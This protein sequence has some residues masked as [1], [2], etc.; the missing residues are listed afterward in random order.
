[1]GD[2]VPLDASLS[3]DPDGAIVAYVW[4]LGNGDRV[5]GR[6]PDYAFQREG[7]YEVAL[8]VTDDSGLPGGT[9]T[10][11]LRVS[12]GPR[13][14]AAPVAD[15]GPDRHAIAGE[16][17]LLDASGSA[18]PD[19]NLI[20]Y[21]WEFGDGRLG[22]GLRLSHAW[23]APGVYTIRLTVQD[24]SGLAND[25]ATD[26]AEIR[27]RPRPNAPPIAA[28]GP[29]REALV[30]ERVVFD[31][32]ASR[33]ED[34]AI[35]GY[36]WD[37]GDG[38]R[39]RGPVVSHAFTRPGVYEVT[40]E[41]EDD[42][43]GG[44]GRATDSATVTVSPV[45]NA[46]PVARAGADRVVAL[47][48]T[49]RLDGSG[50][51]DADGNLIA[52]VW[53]LG[54]GRRATGPVVEH[55][56]D[57]P[58]LYPVRLTVQ[59]DSGRPNDRAED[60]LEIRVNAP[61][62]AAA[63]PD[64]AA[65][66]GA[67][68]ALDGS[69]AQDP[70]GTLIRHD[71]RMTDAAGETVAEAEGAEAEIP[72]EAP[73]RFRV[74][75]TVEDDAGVANS[76]AEAGFDLVVNAAPV[77]VAGPDLEVEAGARVPFD[78]GQSRDAD[79]LLVSYDWAFGNGDRGRGAQ[80]VYAY[81]EP[82]E[83]VVTLTVTD[84]S[85]LPNATA[86]DRMT[87]RVAPRANAAPVAEAGPDREVLVGERLVLDGGD[88]R[89]PDGEILTYRWDFGDGREA[90][91]PSPSHA[92]WTPGDYT[93]RLTVTDDSGRPNDTG[94]DRATIRVR[95]APN[96][97]PVAEAG[98]DR[99]V[100]VGDRVAFD[101]SASSDPD[102]S[103]L[104]YAWDFGDGAGA[105]GPRALYVYRAPGDYAVTL[106]VRDDGPGDGAAGTDRLTVTVAPN[107][108]WIAVPERAE[109]EVPGPARGD[110]AATEEDTDE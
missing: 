54:D 35:L 66:A 24:D 58:G 109:A 103:I 104:S 99:R 98:P 50:S 89:D 2:L 88:S 92:Y 85:G 36:V 84:D 51:G 52:W 8:S 78:A 90:V 11:S 9:A 56:Y 81:H 69:R 15:A 110:G 45:P 60:G 1:M 71:W 64:R 17:V 93:L 86:S 3:R 79:G 22:E 47:G 13:P 67:V 61:P 43:P 59:D 19:G 97:A 72:L 25:R 75:L 48:E 63:G 40:L 65:A 34:G 77:A 100:R 26:T 96:V 42:G 30:G 16:P 27:I 82:G 18:D 68:L 49:V 57:A 83:Y 41:V 107:P 10:D 53:D 62:V 37:F 39:G 76:V 14:N 80:P 102:G 5:A 38:G 29:D 46:P 44:D 12:V 91:G 108:D 101:G 70:D 21:A 95:A 31:G 23:M 6:A 33:D 74:T 55:V 94:S 32:T 28:A 20:G 7:T 106:T 4:D 87:V 73:G 105:R